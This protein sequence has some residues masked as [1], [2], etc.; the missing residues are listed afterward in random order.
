MLTP[1]HTNRS[2]HTGRTDQGGFSLIE[3]LVVVTI[4]GILAAVAIVNVRYAQRKAREAALKD[5]LFSMRKAIDNFQA[6][7]QHFPTT[8]EELT[9][10]Y[11]RF[12]PK[13]PITEQADWET[14]MDNPMGEDELSASTDPD[15]IAQPGI[16][17]VK[18]KAPGSTLDN[19]PY[20]DL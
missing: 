6:D 16:I 1:D 5:N 15:D 18:S 3:L 14:V 7:K 20:A 8:L 19:V 11:L 17:D 9:P 10:N 2:A 4:I 13:D 12:I